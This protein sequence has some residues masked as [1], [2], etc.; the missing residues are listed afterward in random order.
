M[1]NKLIACAVL[2]TSIHPVAVADGWVGSFIPTGPYVSGIDN[3]HFRVFGVP[4]SAGCAGGFVYVSGNDPALKTFVP[5]LLVAISLGRTIN[6]N[7]TKD[8]GS[9]CRV[10]DINVG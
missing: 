2:L 6:A 3:Y 7:V 10:V 8:G 1:I 4:S 5:T 9:W